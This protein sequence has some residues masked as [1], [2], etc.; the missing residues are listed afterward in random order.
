MVFPIISFNY[1]SIF[2]QQT[3]AWI[4][5]FSASSLWFSFP[6]SFLFYLSFLGLCFWWVFCS[7]LVIIFRIILYF[8]LLQ[9]KWPLLEPLSSWRIMVLKS[10]INQII[11]CERLRFGHLWTAI[12]SLRSSNA[13]QMNKIPLKSNKINFFLLGC[14]PRSRTSFCHEFLVSKLLSRFRKCWEKSSMHNPVLEFFSCV[15]KRDIWMLKIS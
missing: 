6:E 1:K 13:N 12:N 3:R 14:S 7:S 5:L 2:V 4:L 15:K 11:F 8:S 9:W 10:W